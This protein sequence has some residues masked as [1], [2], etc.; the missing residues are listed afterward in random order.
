MSTSTS[1][2]IDKY[3]ATLGH[4]RVNQLLNATTA[5][6]AY[7]TNQKSLWSRFC[8]YFCLGSERKTVRALFNAIVNPEKGINPEEHLNRFKNLASY[9]TAENKKKFR[10]F[11]FPGHRANTWK[12]EFRI[13]DSVIYK[14]I[15]RTEAQTHPMRKKF[16]LDAF[17]WTVRNDFSTTF[18]NLTRKMHSEEE[19]QTLSDLKGKLPDDK[20]QIL[21]D[22]DG[23]SG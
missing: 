17:V 12:Y 22:D 4:E 10:A 18:S 16:G 6:Q 8:N 13:D 7:R 2:T 11:T 5:E 9:A 20:N 14:S 1:F 15:D 21:S 3:S 19:T 23:E